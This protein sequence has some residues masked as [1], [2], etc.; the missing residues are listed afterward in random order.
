M[1]YN[2]CWKSLT[3]EPRSYKCAK[4]YRPKP[5]PMRN[6]SPLTMDWSIRSLALY[7]WMSDF[8]L[9]CSYDYWPW[10]DSAFHSIAYHPGSPQGLIWAPELLPASRIYIN[11]WFYF[12]VQVLASQIYLF[13]FHF[14]IDNI[15]QSWFP[16]LEAQQCSPWLHIT[17][18]K[19]KKSKYIILIW[20][21]PLIT[22]I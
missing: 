14:S 9:L 6:F 16:S 8:N 3:V 15:W 10:Y 18:I 12:W 22:V 1:K 11:L 7:F 5:W 2:L 17:K 20:T 4:L 21:C 19:K 13:C